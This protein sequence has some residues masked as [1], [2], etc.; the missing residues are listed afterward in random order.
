[1]VAGVIIKIIMLLLGLGSVATA[2][3]ILREYKKFIKSEASDT[4]S[5]AENILA[6]GM[7]FL[8]SIV[9]LTLA[10]FCAYILCVQLYVTPPTWF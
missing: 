3:Y 4:A 8:S 5:R 2:Y 6:G 10:A 1:M 7:A 9:L